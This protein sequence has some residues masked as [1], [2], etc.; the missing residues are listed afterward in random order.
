[1][2]NLIK[3]LLILFILHGFNA[4]AN[5]LDDFE[6]IGYED[7]LVT[8]V[9]VYEDG[10]FRKEQKKASI[11]GLLKKPYGL[12]SPC[13]VY[14]FNHGGHQFSNLIQTNE[15]FNL[16]LLKKGIC[17]FYPIRKGYS[18]SLNKTSD[19]SPSKFEPLGCSSYADGEFGIESGKSDV[20]ALINE[21]KKVNGINKQ[22]MI[23]AGHS[24]GGLLA[25][26]IAVD[27]L[28]G[29]I[30]IFNFAGGWHQAGC[31]GVDFS[32]YKMNDVITKIEIPVFSYY[33][34]KDDYFPEEHIRKNFLPILS[35]KGP[36]DISTG[37][38]NTAYRNSL[39]WM[40]DLIRIIE[41]N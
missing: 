36:V 37:H 40:P 35:K 21:L 24:R 27:K 41:S 38:H 2:T 18:S 32:T 11:H 6:W 15:S 23:I 3:K 25:L 31:I 22:R 30:G 29:I 26:S 28:P 33:G 14:I 10:W 19:P 7:F 1:M 34:T 9:T 17:V 16:A 39:L 4:M 8:A 13:P 12:K 5:K 20:I